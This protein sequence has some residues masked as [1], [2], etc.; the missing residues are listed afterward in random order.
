MM[1]IIAMAGEGRRF[2]ERGF[3]QP[4]YELIVKGRPLFDWALDSIREW[5][6][7][8]TFRFIARQGA[9]VFVRARCRALGIAHGEVVELDG[10][11]DGQATTVLRGTVSCDPTEP[12]LIY[13]IDTHQRAGAVAPHDIH[14]TYDG[15]VVL[16]RAPGTHWSFAALDDAGRVTAVSEKVRISDFASTGM[17]YFHSRALFEEAYA[18]HAARTKERHGEVFVMPLYEALL[19]RGLHIGSTVIPS[20]AVIPLGTPEEVVRFDPDFTPA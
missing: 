2:R 15:W 20:D 12:I 4:K 3:T 6:P 5:F 8:A 9:D 11:T 14:P 16:F 17:Y 1:I 18:S 10:L 19:E 7:T 13:N